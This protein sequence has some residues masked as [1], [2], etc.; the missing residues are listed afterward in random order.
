V[1][2]ATLMVHLELGHSNTG[3][4]R[5]AGDVAEYYH[6]EVIG[7]AACQPQMIY[8]DGFVAGDLVQDVR[9][10][11]DRELGQAEAEFRKALGS[12]GLTLEWR[13][14]VTLGTP[15]SYIAG[16]AR[17]ADLVLTGVDHNSSLFDSSRHVDMGDLIMR[18]GRPLLIVPALQE[19]LSLEHMVVAWQDTRE[20]QRAALDALP[21]LKKAADVTV[22]EITTAQDLTAA[23]ARVGDVAAWLN[24]HDVRAEWITP[25]SAG[26]DARQLNEIAR[27]RDADIVVAG[28]YGHNR[29]REWVL[30][31]VTRDFLLRADRCA[32]LSH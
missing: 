26:D 24:R 15:A 25:L 23:G 28:A 4:L 5:I 19:R 17:R 21:L 3:V 10:E 2:Y 27:D 14:A 22:V 7:I 16:E 12:R 20:T 11:L 9:D 18:M 6:A 8:G 13:S 29:L 31:G 1:T 30:G 32:L